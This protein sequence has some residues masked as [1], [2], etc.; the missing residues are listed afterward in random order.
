M[1]FTLSCSEIELTLSG[2]WGFP[3]TGEVTVEGLQ[4]T[5]AALFAIDAAGADSLLRV[6]L[7]LSFKVQESFS[8]FLQ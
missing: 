3:N 4:T 7:A 8:C 2:V 6:G 5:D 1:V